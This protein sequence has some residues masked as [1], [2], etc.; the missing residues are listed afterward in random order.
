MMNESLIQTKIRL[1]YSERGWRLW[2]NNVGAFKTEDGR[3]IRYGLCNDSAAMNKRLKSSD[4]IGIRPVRITEDMVGQIIGQFAAV[5]CKPPGWQY[6]G[7]DRERAQL[8][9]LD[10]VLSLGGYGRFESDV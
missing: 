2:R 10:L 6:R 8:R 5:E 1:V 9:F 3:F 4:L 7:T